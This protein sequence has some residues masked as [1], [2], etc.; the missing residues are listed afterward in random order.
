VSLVSTALATM[1]AVAHILELP[2]KMKLTRD[3]Y[4]TAQQ[5]Y[6]GWALAAVPVVSALA[7]TAAL[8][9]GERRRGRP[10]RLALG[11]LLCFA[12]AQGIFWSLIFPANQLT[13]NWTELPPRWEAVR[14]RW[15]YSHAAAAMLDFFALGLLIRSAVAA[16]D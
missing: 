2:G 3:Q 9:L 5:I 4:L 15:E 7:S 16:A 13:N 12:G 1:P 14:A 11:G 6:R 8:V 10:A